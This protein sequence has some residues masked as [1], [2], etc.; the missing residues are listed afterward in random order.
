MVRSPR[1]RQQVMSATESASN[2]QSPAETPDQMM[3][4][5]IHSGG[6]MPLIRK[7]DGGTHTMGVIGDAIL[8]FPSSETKGF[9]RSTSN[10]APLTGK[11][12]C[13]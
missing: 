2:G 13:S 1:A 6:A 9:Q 12:N 7:E 10:R 5:R 3:A 11:D 8:I 4:F